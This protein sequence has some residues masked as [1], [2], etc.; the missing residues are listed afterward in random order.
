[1]SK[2]KHKSVDEVASNLGNAETSAD[3]S[4]LAITD[5]VRSII[6]GRR[7]V[8][9]PIGS[10][11]RAISDASEAMQFAVQTRHRVCRAHAS[12]LKTAT[13]AGLATAYGDF[14]PCETNSLP[15]APQA[16]GIVA[17]A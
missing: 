16:A 13:E 17:V 1:M 14:W 3:D 15:D 8:D 12:L 6:E 11:Q 9:L 7:R 5:L 2:F 10:V 4:I